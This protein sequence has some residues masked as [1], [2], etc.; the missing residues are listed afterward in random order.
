[1]DDLLRKGN[2]EYRKNVAK[3]TAKNVLIHYFHALY[4]KCGLDWTGDVEAEL[5]GIVDDIIT[6]STGE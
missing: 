6:A 3:A 2:T 4:L 1:M 5:N